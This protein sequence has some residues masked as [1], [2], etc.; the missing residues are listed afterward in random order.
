MYAL[1]RDDGLEDAEEVTVVRGTASLADDE[2]DTDDGVE[3]ATRALGL[4]LLPLVA[5]KPP[6]NPPYMPPCFSLR[7]TAALLSTSLLSC[8]LLSCFRGGG[9]ACCGG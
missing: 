9:C 3:D 8:S 6:F 2:D 7:P 4:P 5:K 1:L